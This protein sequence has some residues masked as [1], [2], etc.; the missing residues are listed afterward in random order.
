[1]TAAVAPALFA[2]AQSWLLPAD[3]TRISSN[4]HEFRPLCDSLLPIAPCRSTAE[5]ARQWREDG[6]VFLRGFIPRDLV[7]AVMDHYRALQNAQRASGAGP[8]YGTRGHPAHSLVRSPQFERLCGFSGFADIASQVLGGETTMLRRR[9]VRHYRGDRPTAS[10]AH[11][12]WSYIDRGADALVTF[13]VPFVPSGLHSGALVYLDQS[14]GIAPADI[15]AA[16]KARSDRPNC[17][18]VFSSDLQGL[19]DVT[20]QPWRY[21][22]LE[23]GD[24]FLHDAMVVHA[25][26]DCQPGAERISTDIRMMRKADRADPRWNTDWAADDGY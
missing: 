11:R 12:D 25:S 24:V 8:G 1:M 23:P 18:K 13:W 19:A 15:P 16:I 26:L 7:L 2:A 21:A 14:R 5:I 4:G 3:Q 17:D 20:G 6:Y 10:R 22:Q 9:I